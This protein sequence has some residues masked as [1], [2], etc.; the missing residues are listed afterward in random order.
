MRRDYRLFLF[1]IIDAMASIDS[2]VRDMD[3]DAFIADDKTFSAVIRK[4]E[5][6]GEAS[7]HVP[8]EVRVQF[9]QIPW[10]A[11][12]GMRDRL[13]HVYFGIDQRLVWETITSVL[14]ELKP[15]LEDLLAAATED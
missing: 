11:M 5:I 1:D 12:A 15:E 3:F 8:Q 10:K 9:P 7:K 4:F 14:P 6:I 2:F 13:I